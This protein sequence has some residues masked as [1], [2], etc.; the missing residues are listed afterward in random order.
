MAKKQ[1]RELKFHLNTLRFVPLKEFEGTHNTQSILKKVFSYLREERN[2]GNGHLI[3]RHENQDKAE[4]RELYMVAHRVIPKE[5]R[6]RCSMAYLRKGKK[7][8]LKPS[9][10]FKLVPLNN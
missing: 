3:D 5:R 7:P 4:P 6:I 1:T 2:K 8:K 10:K 9:A